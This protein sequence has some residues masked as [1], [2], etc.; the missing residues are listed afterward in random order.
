MSDVNHNDVSES[1]FLSKG[2]FGLLVFLLPVISVKKKKKLFGLL[3]IN[4]K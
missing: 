4:V 2:I 3:Y 1:S